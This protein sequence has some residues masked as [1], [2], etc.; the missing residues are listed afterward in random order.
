MRDLHSTISTAIALA[1]QTIS[2]NT[3][4]AGAIIDTQGFEGL[5]FIVSTGTITDGSYAFKVETGN[6]SGLS[7]AVDITAS[8]TQVV[9]GNKDALVAADDDTTRRLGVVEFDRYVRISLV[10]TGVTTGGTNFS[11][12]AV[13]AFAK[14][15]PT[16]N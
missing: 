8:T 10:S 4:T 1:N 16:D 7:D 14:S 6:D 15:V 9:I 2:T 11:A 3:T 13:K 5:E 12:V